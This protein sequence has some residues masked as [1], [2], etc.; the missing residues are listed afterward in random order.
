MKEQNEI[1][2]AL[3][4]L[5]A[6]Y[7]DQRVD[8]WASYYREGGGIEYIASVQSFKF[9][10]PARFSING[11][12]TPVAAAEDLIKQVG[13]LDEAAQMAQELAELYERVAELENSK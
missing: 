6:F 10:Q 9:R 3:E 5:H 11:H 12:K 7:P 1:L 8:I 4:K 13:H 2:E